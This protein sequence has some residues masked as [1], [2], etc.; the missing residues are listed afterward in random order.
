MPT[1]N[2][3]E[4]IEELEDRFPELPLKCN[5]KWS[6]I[7][8]LG[9][10]GEI[11]VLAEPTDDISLSELLKFAH[12]KQIKVFVVG[13]GSNIVGSDA[14]FEGIVVK[15]AQNDFVRIKA[16]HFHLTVGAGVRLAD[17]TITAARRGFGGIV[18]LAAIPG[19]VGG[20][21]RMNA[22]AHGVTIGDYVVDICGYDMEGNAVAIDASE[23]KWN[24][25]SSSLP[26]NIIITGAILKLP[27]CDK[28]TE[29]DKI[30]E[31]KKSR[32][33]TDPRGHSAG[34]V[35]TNVSMLDPA[36]KLIDEAGLKE[37]IC[38]GA[39]ISK[40]HANYIMNRNH[41]SEDNFLALMEKIRLQIAQDTGFYLRP[42][43]IF[44]NYDRFEELM[45]NPVA[46]RVAVL[47]GGTSS[48]REVSLNSGAAISDALRN[49]G[50]RVDEID[51]KNCELPED[52]FKADVVFPALHGGWGEDGELQKLLEEK[53]IKFVGCGS[54]ASELVFDKIQSKKL[55]DKEGILT[56]RW[57]VVKKESPEKPEDM[58]FPLVVKAPR[59][60]STVGIYIVNNQDEYD[61]ALP[62]AFKFDSNILVEEFIEG[63]EMTIGIIKDQALSPVEIVPPNGFYDYDAK[64]LHKNGHT[65][66]LCPPESISIEIQKV[67][68]DIALKFYHAAD[69]RHLLRVDFIISED[70]KP[71]VI[72]ANNLPGFTANSLV[73]KAYRQT[74]GS[75]EKLCVQLVQAA[76]K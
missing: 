38:G 49:A 63:A 67:A 75:M 2:F 55:L 40:K 64:Y 24:Y 41:A 15:L 18:P 62:E 12:K 35:F 72:E 42:E 76:L 57:A 7:T 3:A 51:I 27:F 36:G 19:T 68:E 65:Q 20:A 33:E 59:Q 60:G 16:G 45:S 9:V 29:K 22:G 53:G 71:Y 23:V 10:G 48:E 61:K 11:P 14:P 32:R 30:F 13:G 52:V 70:G 58:E 43:V 25:R 1:L 4:L 28:E 47:K 31:E 69:C 34:C 17:L 50:Y 39:K 66:Y 37:T 8:S 73:P 5:V 74:K 54:V 46:P 26:D 56:P 21:L 44:S 6:E